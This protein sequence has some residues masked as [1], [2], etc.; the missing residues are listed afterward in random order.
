M[1]LT[2]TVG[3]NLPEFMIPRAA[4]SCE[5]DIGLLDEFAEGVF[6]EEDGRAEKFMNRNAFESV[7]T[8][9]VHATRDMTVR[10]SL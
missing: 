10:S 5:S 2:M 3:C 1:P 8:C 4:S 9:S 6:T 7:R